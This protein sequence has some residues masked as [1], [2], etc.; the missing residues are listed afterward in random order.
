MKKKI[1]LV[2][3]IL[4]TAVIAV[5][6]A[7][8]GNSTPTQSV[9]F[10]TANEV[11][12]KDDGR[13]TLTY[14][15]LRE[16]EAIGTY[17]TTGECVIGAEVTV[18]EEKV[19]N[20]MG[21][22]FTSKLDVTEDLDGVST[23]T[24]M[25]TQSLLDTGFRVQR[26]YR[27][28]TTVADGVTRTAEIIGS[29]TD[30]NYTYTYKVD[31]E[32]VK[33]GELS[34]SAFASSAYLDNDFIYQVARLLTNTSG[35]T[36]NV[37]YYNYDAD[38]NL[39]TVTLEN[40]SASVTATNAEVKGLRGDFADREGRVYLGTYLTVSLTRDFPGSG[41]SFSCRVIT[42][43]TESEKNTSLPYALPA[44]IKEG[45]VEYVLTG[46]ARA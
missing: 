29:Y 13:E 33:K 27:K 36:F 23:H 24:V 14:D 32:E 39:S 34:H 9:L 5:V 20:A 42:S 21:T 11:W 38:G 12:G 45:D 37:P 31:G 19:Q 30:D 17:V 25:E 15:V 4:L 44:Y 1:L 6:A 41:T 28:T 26:S 18:G 22:Y 7:A 43:Y 3:A 40:V 16:G 35:L 10:N 8:C 2:C 46:E